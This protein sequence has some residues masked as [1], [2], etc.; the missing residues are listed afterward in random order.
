MAHVKNNTGNFEWYTPKEYLDL[1][2]NVLGNIDTDPASS[3]TAN[4]Y[5]GATTY[6]T[7]ANCGLLRPWKGTVWL[8]P[9]YSRGLVEKFVDKLLDELENCNTEEA[10][11]LTNNATET[12]WWQK[13][14]DS[15]YCTAMCFP[16]GRIKYLAPD[17]KTRNSPLQGQTF[18][19]FGG[20]TQ[21][22]EK[23]FSSVGVVMKF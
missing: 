7:E 5:V 10:I 19:Y 14:A 3:D 18:A 21:K 15:P 23:E 1:A 8:N 9:P 12:K 13:L 22:F 4:T 2:R 6:Y 17:L 20:N 11:V 16:K